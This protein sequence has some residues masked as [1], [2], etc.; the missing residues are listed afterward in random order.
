MRGAWAGVLLGFALASHPTKAASQQDPFE[1]GEATARAGLDS[2]LVAAIL[3]PTWKGYRLGSHGGR[4][5]ADLKLAGR[6]VSGAGRVGI[7]AFLAGT[8]VKDPMP[9]AV[10]SGHA[11]AGIAVSGYFNG[12]DGAVRLS[13]ETYRLS[14][15][16]EQTAAREIGLSFRGL[17]WEWGLE[18]LS[19][20]LAGGVYRGGG[21]FEGTRA[22]L[23][24]TLAGGLQ[25]LARWG[26]RDMGAWLE[27]YGSWSDYVDPDEAPE[28]DSYSWYVGGG[29]E[30][31]RSALALSFRVRWVD[32]FDADGAAWSE[33]AI[34]IWPDA[35]DSG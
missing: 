26:F 35:R 7:S 23:N 28:L 32:A 12:G 18:E 13:A 10:S 34:R 2:I 24:F 22:D 21:R 30:L 27:A 15:E 31:D 25:N 19:P 1:R 17:E 8:A 33:L 3:K 4:F 6:P 29:L 9:A 20:R 11:G 5:F 14:T 16:H